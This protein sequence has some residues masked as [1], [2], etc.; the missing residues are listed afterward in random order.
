MAIDGE[1]VW[2]SSGGGD[3][4]D[5]RRFFFA[6]YRDHRED[7]LVDEKDNSGGSVSFT[8]RTEAGLMASFIEK[9]GVSVK[10][11]GDMPCALIS[12][13]MLDAPKVLY[14]KKVVDYTKEDMAEIV[15]MNGSITST[16]VT[17]GEIKNKRDGF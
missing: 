9:Y 4:A 17:M 3:T 2:A 5:G 16:S 7:K 10:E 14:G 8:S 11:Y 1:G 13:M 6:Q 12:L 15:D